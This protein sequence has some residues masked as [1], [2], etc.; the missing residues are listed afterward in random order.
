MLT[1]D[2]FAPVRA[3]VRRPREEGRRRRT[4]RDRS[5][6][7]GRMSNAGRWSLFPGIVPE[8][9]EQDSLNRWAWQLLRR[10]GV[11]F[12]DLLMRETAAPTWSQLVPVLRRLEAREKSAAGVSCRTW[13]A[14]NTR[15]VTPSSASVRCAIASHPTSA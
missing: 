10:W 13:G 4:A 1:S 12:R 6:G 2:A 7:A 9:S 8:T 5:N 14:S 11:V 3:L 15:R